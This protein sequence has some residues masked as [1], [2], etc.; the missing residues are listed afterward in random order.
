MRKSPDNRK[1]DITITTI[2]VAALG[3]LVLV[4]MI[5]VFTGRLNIFSTGIDD[6]QQGQSKCQTQCAGQGM[7]FARYIAPVAGQTASCQSGETQSYIGFPK[8]SACC[9][10]PKATS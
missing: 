4:V 1:A 2:I 10:K 3:L 9:C 8:D 7:D 5:L 6:F